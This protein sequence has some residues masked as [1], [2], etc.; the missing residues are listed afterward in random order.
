MFFWSMTGLFLFSSFISCSPKP[1]EERVSPVL[2]KSDSDCAANQYC[3]LGV[4]ICKEG[5]RLLSPPTPNPP[6]NNE[7]NPPPPLTNSFREDHTSSG[8]SSIISPSL[9][10]KASA[11]SVQVAQIQQVQFTS[12]GD[13]PQFGNKNLAYRWYFIDSPIGSKGTFTDADSPSTHIEIQTPGKYVAEVELSTEIGLT[14]TC[15]VSL[16][17]IAGPGGYSQCIAT[18]NGKA[19]VDIVI[20]IDTSGSMGD[21]SMELSRTLNNLSRTIDSLGIS[22]K[23]V[24]LADNSVSIP[25][26]LGSDSNRFLHH[27]TFVDSVNALEVIAS[28]YSTYYS[29]LRPNAMLHFLVISDDE[30]RMS[31]NSFDDMI[32]GHS[33]KGSSPGI[34][35]SGYTFHAVVS[36]N[37]ACY[38]AS[39]AGYNYITLVNSTG[40]VFRSICGSAWSDVFTEMAQSAAEMAT[41][42]Y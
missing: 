18:S 21:E 39:S 27:T 15:Q 4:G 32:L 41:C 11:S 3:N 37:T 29:F 42:G 8:G 34:A 33:Q 23:V 7:P 10:C 35:P 16:E 24:L 25:P 30:S 6:T 36:P 17:L 2:C 40:G 31:P 22:Y 12:Q 28:D 9:D 13:D 19:Q 26:P 5:R 14:S 1:K 20:A 38:S